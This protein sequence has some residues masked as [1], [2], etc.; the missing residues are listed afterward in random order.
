VRQR[1]VR[2]GRR[3]FQPRSLTLTL[4]AYRLNLDK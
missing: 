1:V 2:A 4:P 3:P